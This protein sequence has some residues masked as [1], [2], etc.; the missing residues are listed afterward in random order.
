VARPCKVL[1]AELK[2][3][4]CGLCRA[5]VSKPNYRS[6]WDDGSEVVQ[7][8][9]SNGKSKMDTTDCIYLGERLPG[10]PCGGQLMR[11]NLHGDITTQFV[12]CKE[13]ARCCNG[14]N[15][16][17]IKPRIFIDQGGSGIGDGLMGLLAVAQLKI[18]RPD[19]HIIYRI[20]HHSRRWVQLFD[21][22]DEL[23]NHAK[24]HNENPVPDAVQINQGYSVEWQSQWR[25]PTKR[26]ERYARNIGASGITIPKLRDNSGVKPDTTFADCVLLCPFSDNAER[27]WPVSQWLELDRMIRGAGYRT[28]VVHSTKARADQ[29]TESVQIVGR[30]PSEVASAMLGAIAVIGNDSGMCHLSG[31]LGV[32]TVVLGGPSRVDGIFGCYPSFKP[33]QGRGNRCRGISPKDVFNVIETHFPE[34][35]P[36]PFVVG[37][38]TLSRYDLLDKCL[39]AIEVST[40]QP[41]KIIV[42]DNGGNYSTANPLVE[43]IKPGRNLGVAASWNLIHR[44]ALSVPTI[45]LNDDIV[46]SPELFERLLN[47][48]REMTLACGWAAFKQNPKVWE[49]VGEYDESF[50]PAYYEDADYYRRI[51]ESGIAWNNI[52]PCGSAHGESQTKHA[53]T[54]AE[55]DALDRAVDLNRAYFESKWAGKPMP[56][57]E[58]IKTLRPF[59]QFTA[60]DESKQL[61]HV[62]DDTWLYEP[63]KPR[64]ICSIL[65]TLH[66]ELQ[67]SRPE[68]A[69]LT[70]EAVWMAR[71]MNDLGRSQADLDWEAPLAGEGKPPKIT[72]IIPTIGRQSL[73][74]SLAAFRGQLRADDEVLLL[75]DGVANKFVR[76]AWESSGLPGRLIE[77]SDGPHNDWGH[78]IRN[79]ALQ[80]VRSG[81]VIH[82]DDDDVY[83]PNGVEVVRDAITKNGLG[84]YVFRFRY[85]G[86][87][88]HWSEPV[89]RFGNIGTPMIVHPVGIQLG[90]WTPHYGGDFDF[91]DETRRLNPGL[92]VKWREEIVATVTEKTGA[93]IPRVA[94]LGLYNSGSTVVAGM[95]HRLGVNMGAPF[96]DNSDDYSERNFYESAHLA[97]HVRRWFDE[98]SGIATVNSEQRVAC[99]KSWSTFQECS[100]HGG[101]IGAKHP[102]LSLCPDDIRAAWGPATRIIWAWRPLEES[103]AGIK[104]RGWFGDQAE[105]LQRKLWDSLNEYYQRAGMFQIQHWWVLRH[106]DEAARWLAEAA[107]IKPTEEQIQNAISFV[108][109]SP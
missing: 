59:K 104:R 38:P 52:G 101:A 33:V 21:G 73:V 94:V 57:F 24:G 19:A 47:D 1:H 44:M 64:Y 32:P 62:N 27:E 72:I 40:L 95:L 90:R 31:L 11:C 76:N 99:L 39:G 106:P 51:C 20:S 103:I 60:E 77:F 58:M 29:F 15:D 93:T 14:C 98:P 12:P 18:D 37:I 22:F 61:V 89:I 70:L 8:T 17:V 84:L 54:D 36:T 5:F 3:E 69:Q 75:S 50:F 105:P 25:E 85:S 30:Q 46:P 6:A 2:P 48:P 108:R 41:S 55:R 107:A 79:Q 10:Q 83:A 13:A 82:F 34:E 78:S 16:K 4:T 96:H 81:Y 92:P 71:R 35:K 42:I 88:V 43:V 65:G 80:Q 100:N 66:Q 102:L 26:W 53:M 45:I 74:E 91:F 86:G 67:F 97:A 7:A 63:G 109:N 68:L 49:T 9:Y 23:R 56:R 87:R 28:A